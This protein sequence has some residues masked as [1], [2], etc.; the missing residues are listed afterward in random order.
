M[1]R[2]AHARQAAAPDAAVRLINWLIGVHGQ[3]H[4]R[5]PP[6]SDAT[7]QVAALSA[8]RQFFQQVWQVRHL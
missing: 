4:R 2:K 8:G 5:A 3:M 7:K 1:V 6:D